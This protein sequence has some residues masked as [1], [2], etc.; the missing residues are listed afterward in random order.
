MA[1]LK[2]SS[3]QLG[4]DEKIARHILQSMQI[5]GIPIPEEKVGHLT[6]II[7]YA[8]HEQTE[9]L[10]KVDEFHKQDEEDDGEEDGQQPTTP[11]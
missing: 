6:D 11:A 10:K 9:T 4:R 7:C 5:E 2:D 3:V 1:Q 8:L